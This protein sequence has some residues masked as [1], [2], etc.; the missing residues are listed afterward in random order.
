MGRSREAGAR[1]YRAAQLQP[2]DAQAALRAALAYAEGGHLAE[3]E[4]AL[5][6]AVER[7]ARFHRA[8]YNL[9]LLLSQTDR[10]K[11]SVDALRRAEAIDRSVPD[12]PYALGTVLLRLGDREGAADA[13]RRV[14]ALQPGNSGAR[15][16]LAAA[17]SPPAST[18]PPR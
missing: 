4:T 18:Q 14:L 5:R 11:E 10:A 3:A 8:W 1:F 6:L 2:T 15:Q 7:D 12:Y 9:G 13:A 16:L 17:V